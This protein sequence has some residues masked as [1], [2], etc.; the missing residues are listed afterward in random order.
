MVQ[1]SGRGSAV[2]ILIL[3][4]SASEL[5]SSVLLHLLLHQQLVIQSATVD[6]HAA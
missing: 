5:T 6:C 4:T 1:V 3:W 2:R